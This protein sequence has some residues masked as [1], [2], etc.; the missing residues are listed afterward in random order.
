MMLEIVLAIMFLIPV[1]VLWLLIKSDLG[2]GAATFMILV[3][4][5]VAIYVGILMA[6]LNIV[7]KK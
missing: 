6:L 1:C 4:F 3:I 5:A 2:A 7:M